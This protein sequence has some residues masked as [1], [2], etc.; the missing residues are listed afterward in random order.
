[1]LTGGTDGDGGG[2]GPTVV[3]MHGFGAS[4]TDLVP[5]AAEVPAPEGTRFVFPEAPLSLP[6]EFGGGDSR[7]WWMIDV[8]RFQMAIMTGRTQELI[9][10]VPEGLAKARGLIVLLL[11]ELV[12]SHAVR[13]ESLILGGFSQ[14]AMLA[15]DVALRTD[16]PLAA[17]VLMSGTFIA[18][19]EWQP[20]MHKRQGLRVLQSHGTADPL[21]PFNIAKQLRDALNDGGLPV[22][23]V[24]FDGGHTIAP[25]VLH[26][27]GTLITETT[28]P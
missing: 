14:G 18:A 27:L 23:F 22:Q 26:K 1:M 20:L 21:L 19:T 4:G 28:S 3:L 7:A 10:Q 2:D 8:M 12:R 24:P 16:E 11:D 6:A 25:Q 13:R 15:C 5:L 9:E 17:L